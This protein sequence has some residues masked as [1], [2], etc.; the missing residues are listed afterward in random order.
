MCRRVTIECFRRQL[1]SLTQNLQVFFEQCEDGSEVI[2]ALNDAAD[3]AQVIDIICMDNSMI[4]MHE[5]E[6]TRR[7][8][9]MG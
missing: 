3:K 4:T 8:R 1:K 9:E 5:L 2:D 7:V 6:A